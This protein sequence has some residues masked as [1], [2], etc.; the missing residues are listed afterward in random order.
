MD[1]GLT[2]EQQAFLREVRKFA[3]DNVPPGADTPA[4]VLPRLAR[5]GLM[6]VAV[7]EAYGGRGLDTVCACIAIR[8]L[9][10]SCPSTAVT[11]HV[12]NFVYCAPLLNQGSEAQKLAFLVPAARGERLGAF[13]LSEPDA[14]ADPSRIRALACRENDSGYR[15]AGRKAWVTNGRLA[16]S[17]LVVA[18]FDP[19]GPGPETGLFVVDRDT[20]G[21]V[22]GEREQT[23]GLRSAVVTDLSLVDCPVGEDRLVGP[24]VDG[25]Q[26]ALTALLASR[27]G[28]AAQSVGIARGAL[29]HLAGESD[30]LRRAAARVEAADLMMYRAAWQVDRGQIS[31]GRASMAKLICSEAAVAATTACLDL[32]GAEGVAEDHPLSRFWRDARVTTIYGGPSEIQRGLIARE[33]SRKA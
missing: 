18:R 31:P 16:S 21:L 15:L 23:L 3:R 32:A 25:L 9:A 1:F 29:D 12:N 30:Q 7:P 4:D 14:G 20:P 24:G 2:A 6:G 19:P 17:Y 28:V 8:E 33:V 26:Q 11:V 27:I 10:R 13:A 5:Q 22:P